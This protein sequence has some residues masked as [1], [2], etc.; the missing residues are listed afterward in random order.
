MNEK[1]FKVS[2]AK[3]KLRKQPSSGIESK[4]I[5]GVHGPDLRTQ[6]RQAAEVGLPMI[7]YC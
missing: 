5:V 2:P 6:A 7:S 4:P 1:Q 3:K